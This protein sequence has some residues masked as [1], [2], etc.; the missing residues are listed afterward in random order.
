MR[1]LAGREAERLRAAA[2]APEYERREL[3][4]DLGTRLGALVRDLGRIAGCGGG[5]EPRAPT[6]PRTAWPG[7][8]ATP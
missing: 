5:T 6:S 1:E 4:A 2:G 8:P 7:C 3:L